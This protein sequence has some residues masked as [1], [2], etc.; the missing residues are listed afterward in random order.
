MA[1]LAAVNVL[2][3]VGSVDGMAGSAAYARHL[4]NRNMQLIF[5]QAFQVNTID[6]AK[7]PAN[8]QVGFIDLGVNNE[9]TTPNPQMTID[10]VDRIYKAGHTIRFIADEHGKQAWKDVLEKCGHTTTEL[11]IKPK[12]REKYS[13]SCAVLK[14]AFGESVDPQTKALLEAGDE[15]DK[16]NFNTHFGRIFNECVKSNIT[17]PTRRPY[18]V[19]HMAF[20]NTADSKIE[21]WM[22]EYQEMQNNLPTI[23]GTC[24]DLGDLIFLHDCTVGRHDATAVFNA[25]YKINSV[26]ISKGTNV[27]YTMSPVVVLKGTNVFLEGK[28]QVGASIGTNKTTIN[29]LKTVQD[30][31]ITASGMPAKV[32]FALKDLDKAI[33]A[34]RKAIENIDRQDLNTAIEALFRAGKIN[35]TSSSGLDAITKGIGNINL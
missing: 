11:S 19:Q 9:G 18:V 33:E 25:A 10:F 12:N 24:Q 29:V 14:K 31:G 30:A 28:S 1:S 20:N 2:V 35:T 6:I 4:Q 15:A 26:V 8:S 17:D 7:W 27:V 16:M 3:A 34:V 21:G 5:T 13:S 32:N 22:K 23:L